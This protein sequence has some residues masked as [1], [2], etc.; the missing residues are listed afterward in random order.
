M[1]VLD[2]TWLSYTL[3]WL[4]LALLDSTTLYHGSTW[5]CLTLLHSIMALLSYA[6]LYYTLPWLYLALLDPSTTLYHGSTW[7]C[8]TLLHS[9]IPLLG[10]TGYCQSAASATWAKTAQVEARTATYFLFVMV[11]LDRPSTQGCSQLCNSQM[12]NYVVSQAS[13]IN[14]NCV[15]PHSQAVRS[16]NKVTWGAVKTWITKRAWISHQSILGAV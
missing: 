11:A 2:S 13:H 10:S 16:G 4:Y 9:T 7:L 14:G 15:H 1:I 3:P 5:L 8:L 12:H 6:W